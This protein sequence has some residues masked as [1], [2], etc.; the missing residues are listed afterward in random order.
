[1]AELQHQLG[2]AQASLARL[3]E[4]LSSQVRLQHVM[5]KRYCDV[6]HF[7]L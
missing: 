1:V 5:I 6:S 2:E 4:Q 3:E 7:V